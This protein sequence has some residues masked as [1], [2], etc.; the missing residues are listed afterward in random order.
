[1][2]I[3]TPVLAAAATL[4]AFAACVGDTVTPSGD[5]G[6]STDTGSPD[7]VVGDATDAATDADAGPACENAGIPGYAN[8]LWKPQATAANS[9]CVPDNNNGLVCTLVSASAPKYAAYNYP[10]FIG[11]D[12]ELANSNREHSLLVKFTV[13]AQAPNT[14][15]TVMQFEFTNHRLL[16]ITGESDNSNNI[17]YR[18]W[19]KSGNVEKRTLLAEGPL[20]KPQTFLI[21]WPKYNATTDKGLRKVRIRVQTSGAESSSTVDVD[22]TIPSASALLQVGTYWNS[23]VTPLAKLG[24]TAVAHFEL[25]IWTSCTKLP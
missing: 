3:L 12:T 11:T 2:R 5:A 8:P 14:E 17:T 13:M 19:T 24:G 6:T 1:M 22:A 10:D 21:E 18:A 15:L 20:N 25:P 9:S 7:S 4:I 23:D 16:V